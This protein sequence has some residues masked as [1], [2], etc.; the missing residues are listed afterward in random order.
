LITV[1]K[2]LSHGSVMVANAPAAAGV[3][4]VTLCEY[5]PMVTQLAALSAA[6]K[7]RYA[8]AHGYKLFFETRRLDDSRPPAW[9]KVWT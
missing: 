8:K 9:S 3:A 5:D 2:C 6:N 7:E 4:I 1:M